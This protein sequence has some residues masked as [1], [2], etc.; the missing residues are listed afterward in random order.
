M[1]T[2]K[3]IARELRAIARLL[4]LAVCDA[5]GD[6]TMGRVLDHAYGGWEDEIDQK[7]DGD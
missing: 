2:G 1:D 7:S 6:Y 4:A 3:E 5:N